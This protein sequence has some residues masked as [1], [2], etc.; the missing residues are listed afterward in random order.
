ETSDRSTFANG[1][2]DAPSRRL[3]RICRAQG[4][5]QALA[6]VRH[7]ATAPSVA[8][9]RSPLRFARR[10]VFSHSRGTAATRRWR[11]F[12]ERNPK[13]PTPL[14]GSREPAVA[15]RAFQR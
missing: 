11:E 12:L 10:C 1:E 14:G 4:N 6:H 8:G 7:G 13:L 15:E 3:A 2:Q 9:D 5:G